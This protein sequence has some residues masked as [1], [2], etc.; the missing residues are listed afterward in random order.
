[1]VNDAHGHRSCLHRS[2]AEPVSDLA[3]VDE[4]WP[5]LLCNKLGRGGCSATVWDAEAAAHDSSGRFV[6]ATRVGVEVEAL[7]CVQRS[8]AAND[9]ANVQAALANFADRGSDVPSPRRVA[10]APR[11][12]RTLAGATGFPTR[13]MCVS[14]KVL[15]ATCPDREWS[16]LRLLARVGSPAFPAKLPGL[17]AP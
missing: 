4:R 11:A 17:A 5:Q 8:P 12:G 6:S 9:A 14:G 10:G 2:A 1:M 7:D 3:V 15:V 16:P 13:H